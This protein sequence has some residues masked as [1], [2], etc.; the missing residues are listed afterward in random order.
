MTSNALHIQNKA[1]LKYKRARYTQGCHIYQ[2]IWDGAV[3]EY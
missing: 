1:E 2:E 3:G